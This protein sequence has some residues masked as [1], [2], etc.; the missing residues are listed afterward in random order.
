MTESI[1][2]FGTLGSGDILTVSILY[3]PGNS[4]ENGILDLE[5]NLIS[6]INLSSSNALSGR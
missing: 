4:Y 2:H 5:L 6:A 3:T 1:L